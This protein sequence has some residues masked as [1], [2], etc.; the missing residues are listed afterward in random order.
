MQFQLS[1][2]AGTLKA[3]E[4]R[5]LLKI[6]E[7]PDIISFAGGLPAPEFFPAK[8]LAQLT[9]EILATDGKVALQ[10]SPTEGYALLREIIA[11]KS[12]A[13]AQVNTVKDEILITAGSQQGLD[14]C[15]KLFLN[16]GDYL[17]CEDPS[18]LGAINVF[19]ACHAKYLT[20][21]MDDNGMIVDELEKLLQSGK[22][23]KFIYTIPDFQNP[24]GVTM[25]V[26]RRKKLVELANQYQIPV[27]E[28]NPYGDVVFDGE[29]LPSIKSF[30]K[31]GWVI[32]LGSFSKTLCPGL[33]IG[34]VC[35]LPELLQ[36]FI[37]LKQIS[38]LQCNTLTQREVAHY[39]RDYDLDKHVNQVI[40]VYRNR[41]DLM[42]NTMKEYFPTNIKYTYPNGGLFTW[43]TLPDHINAAE[44]LEEALKDKV[45]FVPGAPFFPNGGH[46]NY[47]RLNYS[48]MSEDKIVEGI[49]RLANVLIRFIS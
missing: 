35:A 42:I 24:T 14:F 18:Y 17:I 41:R 23:A 2:R 6:T 19:N 31:N 10:Y 49:K 37:L 28:D 26:E 38:D 32:Y 46:K 9:Q 8:E 34:W 44:L 25:S 48:N 7:Q 47:L 13:K 27:I 33:R 3:S 21:P 4:I 11:T 45:A 36:K 40:T 16:D 29:R 22:R 43:V 5:E 39:M 12:M 20:I 30:D 1:D 15:A